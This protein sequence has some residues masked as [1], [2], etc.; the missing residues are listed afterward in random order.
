MKDA[1]HFHINMDH[2]ME[3]NHLI[4]CAFAFLVFLIPGPVNGGVSDGKYSNSPPFQE[5][6]EQKHWKSN[7]FAEKAT[8]NP[9]GPRKKEDTAGSREI[10]V[11][12]INFKGDK[13]GPEKVLIYLNRFYLPQIFAIQGEKPRIVIDI[14]N[15]FS[16]KGKSVIDVD[17]IFVKKIRTHL[18]S[19]TRKLRIVLDLNPSRNYVADQSFF[20]KDNLFC[21]IIGPERK[22]PE[23]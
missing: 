13:H 15:V 8:G 6:V 14:E 4:V 20:K 10:V 18:H 5:T 9:I 17:G 12:K 16:W 22:K 7:A 19:V 3:K 1:L 11:K 2:A 21:I 23:Q